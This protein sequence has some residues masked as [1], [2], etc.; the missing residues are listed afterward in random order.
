MA[1]LGVI[2]Q[3]DEL[4]AQFLCCH[5]AVA[6]RAY[7]ELQTEGLTLE[8]RDGP[9]KN[10]LGQIFRDNSLAARQYMTECGLTP[11]ARSKIAADNEGQMSLADILFGEAAQRVAEQAE[12]ESGGDV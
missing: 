9:K 6:L 8:T 2:T 11:A 10:P 4:M 5:A 7:D 1:R 3:A 12:A